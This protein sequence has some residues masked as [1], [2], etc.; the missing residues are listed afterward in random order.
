MQQEIDSIEHND[1]W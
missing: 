1:T